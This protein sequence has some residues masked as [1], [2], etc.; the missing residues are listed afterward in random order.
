[1]GEPT[2]AETVTPPVV[3]IEDVRCG[4]CGSSMN[5]ESCDGCDGGYWRWETRREVGDIKQTRLV[6]L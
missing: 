2:N 3:V 5:W 6:R 1:M 4:R